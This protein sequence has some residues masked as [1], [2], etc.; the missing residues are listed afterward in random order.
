MR[1]IPVHS[2]CNILLT[3]SLVG[4]LRM[5]VVTVIAHYNELLQKASKT[6]DQSKRYMLYLNA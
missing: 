2:C 6:E 3:H 5:K 1:L 4:I